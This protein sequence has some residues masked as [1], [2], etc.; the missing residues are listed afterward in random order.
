M[1]DA[2]APPSCPPQRRSL[3]VYY[4]VHDGQEAAARAAIETMQATLTP[5]QPGLCMRL[6]RKDDASGV[7]WMEVYEHPAGV[8]HACE[9]MLETLASALPD[10]LFGKRHVEVFYPLARLEV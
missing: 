4:R 3:Y 2:V 8:S 7:T 6:M 9:A 10:G 1:S 5:L